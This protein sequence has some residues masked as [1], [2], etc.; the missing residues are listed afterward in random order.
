MLLIVQGFAAGLTLW[1]FLCQ[2]V[3]ANCALVIYDS[4]RHSKGQASNNITQMGDPDPQPHTD[5]H[6]DPILGASLWYMLCSAG[7]TASKGSKKTCSCARRQRHRLTRGH[8]RSSACILL[9]ELCSQSH[10]PCGKA[11][12]RESKRYRGWQQQCD[13][14]L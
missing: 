3:G 11:R 12:R 13:P 1:Q 5:T 6:T 9:Y 14:A 8:E 10:L 4:P 7:A 2:G